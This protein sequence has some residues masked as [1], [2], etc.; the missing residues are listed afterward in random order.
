M[1]ARTSGACAMPVGKGPSAICLSAI[2]T[3]TGK[4]AVIMGRVCARVATMANTAR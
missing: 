1:R 4:D 3:A 2:K